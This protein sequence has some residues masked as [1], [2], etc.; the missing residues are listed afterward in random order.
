MKLIPWQPLTDIFAPNQQAASAAQEQGPSKP[1]EHAA[2]GAKE[3]Q[4]VCADAAP[5]KPHNKP[6]RPGKENIDSGYHGMSTEEESDADKAARASL[7]APASEISQDL[8]KARDSQDT[9]PIIYPQVLMDV[10]DQPVADQANS[11]AEGRDERATTPEERNQDVRVPEATEFNDHG[12]AASAAQN[13]DA[14]SVVDSPARGPAVADAPRSVAHGIDRRSSLEPA[15]ATAASSQRSSPAPP[16]VRK[17]SLSFAALPAREPLAPKLSIEH[18]VSHSTHWNA[19]SL[20]LGRVGAVTDQLTAPRIQVGQTIEGM[21]AAAV[22]NRMDMDEDEKQTA[23]AK[24]SEDLTETRLHRKTS[25]QRLHERI[26]QL[27]QSQAS[28][29]TKSI[30]SLLHP[31]SQPDPLELPS[32]VAPEPVSTANQKQNVARQQHVDEE[33]SW[34][35]PRKA[36]APPEKILSDAMSASSREPQAAMAPT[37]QQMDIDIP[38]ATISQEEAIVERSHEIEAAR[39]QRVSSPAVSS[40]PVAAATELSEERATSERRPVEAA[41]PPRPTD[42]G[43]MRPPAAAKPAP[44]SNADGPL[45]ASKAKLSSILKSARGIFASSAGVSAQAKMETMSPATTM[46][47]RSQT[48]DVPAAAVVQ[49]VEMQDEAVV[50]DVGQEKALEEESQAPSQDPTRNAKGSKR[51]VRPAKA[52]ASKAK[53]VPVAIKVGTASQRELDNRK[54]S[55]SC[56]APEEP[57]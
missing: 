30:P 10:D 1:A 5:V 45:T 29:P 17:S 15:Q 4:P 34:M 42:L 50:P 49:E 26:S 56:L 24:E 22:G 35:P 57:H 13:T 43:T 48:N 46:R 20:G 39:I 54:V 19:T 21:E 28:R 8:P 9:V 52:A 37:A 40:V 23:S 27:G 7:S 38:V 2:A 11:M 41:G 31:V 36:V 16:V 33:D 12:A 44:N 53:P 18:G 55:G 51:P 14:Q 3:P 25:T 47:L 6:S 32:P